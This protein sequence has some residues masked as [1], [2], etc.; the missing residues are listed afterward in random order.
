[1]NKHWNGDTGPTTVYP[2]SWRVQPCVWRQKTARTNEIMRAI[3][4]CLQK[5]LRSPFTNLGKCLICQQLPVTE[6]DLK[7]IFPWI[8]CRNRFQHSTVSAM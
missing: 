6:D 8:S 7:L 5:S 3:F 1:M 4:P 2:V